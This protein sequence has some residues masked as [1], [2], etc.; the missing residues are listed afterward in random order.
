MTTI[1]FTHDVAKNI[2]AEIRAADECAS[3]MQSTHGKN[4]HVYMHLVTQIN[5]GFTVF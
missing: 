1:Y 3:V 2:W 5:K 4:V